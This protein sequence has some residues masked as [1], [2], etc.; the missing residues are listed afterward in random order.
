[1]LAFPTHALEASAL[2]EAVSRL[3]ERARDPSWSHEEFL[4]A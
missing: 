2:R 4:I 1:V 3:A